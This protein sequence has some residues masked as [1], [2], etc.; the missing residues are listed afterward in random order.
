MESALPLRSGGASW[1]AV[2]R[3]TG[4]EIAAKDPAANLETSSTAYV[5]ATAARALAAANRTSVTTRS[6]LLPTRPV[7]A[8][9]N[10]ERSAYAT[11]KTVTRC[12]AAPTETE[13]SPATPPNSP[14]TM[15]VPVPVAKVASARTKTRGLIFLR[16]PGEPA[17]P[18]V[19]G[20][21]GGSCVLRPSACVVMLLLAG[22]RDRAAPPLSLM[23]ASA[24]SFSS[25]AQGIGE[26]G[27]VASRTGR[28]RGDHPR[29]DAIGHEGEGDLAPAVRRHPLLADERLALVTIGCGV[30][31]EQQ[32]RGQELAPAE[33]RCV[34][35]DH[36]IS[37]IPGTSRLPLRVSLRPTPRP[38]GV[39]THI[40]MDLQRGDN[41]GPKS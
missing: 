24:T 13:R 32:A 26:L 15:K 18:A 2:A 6:R 3:A 9:R 19:I 10:G 28:G 25:H 16:A 35:P 33:P 31:E 34:R 21:L 12:P 23:T 7:A 29:N 40:A 37:P 5:G 1:A 41:S 17:W 27:G 11:A 4:V 38:S 8:T 36:G 14:V 30:G 20:A 22:G 39:G